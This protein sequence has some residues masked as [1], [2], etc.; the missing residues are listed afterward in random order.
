MEPGCAD[1]NLFADVTADNVWV[2]QSQ[3]RTWEDLNRHLRSDPL[4]AGPRSDGVV[5]SAT[6][7]MLP[8]IRKRESGSGKRIPVIAMTAN[9]MARDR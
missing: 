6:G 9:A 3:W 2:L 1:C 7:W 8:E 5:R 4:S